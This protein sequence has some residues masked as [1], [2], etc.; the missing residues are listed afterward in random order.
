MNRGDS[1]EGCF[2][3]WLSVD[4]EAPCPVPDHGSCPRRCQEKTLSKLNVSRSPCSRNL[5]LHILTAGNPSD[6]MGTHDTQQ[7]PGAIWFYHG[8]YVQQMST[9]VLK[10]AMG[11]AQRH[12]QQGKVSI[13]QTPYPVFLA[14]HPLPVV[15]ARTEPML[16][17]R[18][19]KQEQAPAL[20]E[21]T[22]SLPSGL[23]LNPS[24]HSALP[25]GFLLLHSSTDFSQSKT[26][27]YSNLDCFPSCV[28]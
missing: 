23:F 27:E 2:V 25:P 12:T 18:C 22:A 16:G 21:L 3:S 15:C 20:R 9:D 8:P 10:E 26:F 17:W 7:V 24:P 11:L 14:R 1:A 6:C 28:C 19:V 13:C 4:R 5:Q